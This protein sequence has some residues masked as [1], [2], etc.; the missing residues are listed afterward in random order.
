MLISVKVDTAGG[1]KSIVDGVFSMML[2][3]PA[4][5]ASCM[6]VSSVCRNVAI[7]STKASAEVD[8]CEGG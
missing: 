7:S 5:M 8:V 4:I 6:S 3:V 2:F 1:I